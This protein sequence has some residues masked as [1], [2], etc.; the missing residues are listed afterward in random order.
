VFHLG[1]P[2]D[3]VACMLG[4]AESH[5]VM[6]VQKRQA[7]SR[8]HNARSHAGQVRTSPLF[9]IDSEYLY[10]RRYERE[11]DEEVAVSRGGNDPTVR[12]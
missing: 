7:E 12:L 11:E 4:T 9:H 6:C 5:Q 3:N 10:M 2:A 1:N 8:K